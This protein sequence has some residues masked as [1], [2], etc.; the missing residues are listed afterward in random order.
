MARAEHRRLWPILGLSGLLGCAQGPFVRPGPTAWPEP[1]ARVHVQVQGTFNE[2][3]SALMP[4]VDEPSVGFYYRSK[5]GARVDEAESLAGSLEIEAA[6]AA[7]EAELH[8]ILAAKHPVVISAYSQGSCVALDLIGRLEP[9]E[10][11]QVEWL[12]LISPAF[13]VDSAWRPRKRGYARRMEQHCARARDRLLAA[14]KSESAARG[15]E[16][17]EALARLILERS[18]IADVDHDRIVEPGHDGLPIERRF[19]QAG[20]HAGWV[21]GKGLPYL[22]LIA[23]IDALTGSAPS[24]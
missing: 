19:M 3:G 5:A 16:S 20:T 7:H 10:L 14:M 1:P 4:V 13:R 18:F 9:S 2:E 21:A 15:G 12:V 23:K 22:E 24:R 8:A 11:D 6:M 17:N